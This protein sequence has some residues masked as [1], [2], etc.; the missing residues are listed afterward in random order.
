MLSPAKDHA[1][2]LHTTLYLSLQGPCSVAEFR[3]RAGILMCCSDTS[4]VL[5]CRCSQP[6]GG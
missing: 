3:P 6:R 5:P 2:H 1:Q 4:A